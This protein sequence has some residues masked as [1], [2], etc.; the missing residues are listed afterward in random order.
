MI[1]GLARWGM[2]VGRALGPCLNPIESVKAA[3]KSMD[4]L[5]RAIG[6]FGLYLPV[7]A[8]F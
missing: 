4:F 2:I 3:I 8:I 5:N 1:S 6:P 7:F